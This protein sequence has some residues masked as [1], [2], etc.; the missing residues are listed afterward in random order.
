MILLLQE[1]SGEDLFSL[2][3][4]ESVNTTY[5]YALL[6]GIAD[7]IQSPGEKPIIVENMVYY[8]FQT[9][10]NKWLIY[11]YPIIGNEVFIPQ[12]IGELGIDSGKGLSF[13]KAFLEF[14]TLLKQ[15]G[16]DK[17]YLLAIRE[18][19]LPIEASDAFDKLI[20]QIGDTISAYPMKHLGYSF[21]NDYYSL[22]RRE[23]RIPDLSLN[24]KSLYLYQNNSTN[25]GF[26]VVSHSIYKLLCDDKYN[27]LFTKNV[28]A[29]WIDFTRKLIPQNAISDNSLRLLIVGNDNS[30]SRISTIK[31]FASLL[32]RSE[33]GRQEALSQLELLKEEYQ[34]L[35][36]SHSSTLHSYSIPI[37]EENIADTVQTFIDQNKADYH[38][39]TILENRYS[40]L[41]KQ[42]KELESLIDNPMKRQKDKQLLVEKYDELLQELNE[43]SISVD[44]IPLIKYL[45]RPVRRFLLYG[46]KG[47]YEL[48]YEIS[49]LYRL[50]HQHF[51]NSH[52]VPFWI[53]NSIAEYSCQKQAKLLTE[54]THDTIT[55]KGSESA[56]LIYNQNHNDIAIKIS[57]LKFPRKIEEN[58][59]GMTIFEDG[60]FQGDKVLPL[61]KLND[62]EVYTESYIYPL[63]GPATTYT[64]LFHY[65]DL[66]VSDPLHIRIEWENYLLFDASTG[67][68]RKEAI[69]SRA[70]WVVVKPEYYIVPEGAAVDYG[71]LDRKWDNYRVYYL[72]EGITGWSVVPIGESVQLVDNRPPLDVKVEGDFV[73]DVSADSLTVYNRTPSL[74]VTIPDRNSINFLIFTIT[75]NGADNGTKT[76]SVFLHAGEL[77]RYMI[78]C[79]D[80]EYRI[81]LSHEKLIGTTF[82]GRCLVRL[83]HTSL[84]IDK[85]HSFIILPQF[86]VQL[87]EKIFSPGFCS[88]IPLAQIQ[89]APF[90][91]IDQKDASI[92]VLDKF[93][94]KLLLKGIPKPEINCKIIIPIAGESPK[95]FNLKVNL[96]VILFGIVD[97]VNQNP[98]LSSSSILL[99]EEELDQ[100]GV[101]PRLHVLVPGGITCKGMLKLCGSSRV[102]WSKDVR[103]TLVFHLSSLLEELDSLPT[104]EVN[105]RLELQFDGNK[106]ISG[107]IIKI[108]RWKV[109]NAK[110]AIDDINDRKELHITWD[111]VGQA[112]SRMYRIWRGDKTPICQFHDPIPIGSREIR[113]TL[114]KDQLLPGLYYIQ[115]CRLKD[116]WDSG[117]PVFP[118]EMGYNITQ[119]SISLKKEELLE[120]GDK[121]LNNGDI[122]TAIDFFKEYGSENNLGMFWL[123]KIVNRYF[124]MKDFNGLQTV[125]PMIMNERKLLSDTDKKGFLIHFKNL[126]VKK[127]LN[128]KNIND[129][130]LH[131]VD[132]AVLAKLLW[133]YSSTFTQY[134]GKRSQIGNLLCDKYNDLKDAIITHENLS[135]IERDELFVIFEEMESYQ[136]EI[137]LRDRIFRDAQPERTI[138]KR[139]RRIT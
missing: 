102:I 58:S 113:K 8:P 22:V 131:Q 34:C 51:S 54:K 76:E 116:E 29:K 24:N 60:D 132:Y 105:I 61:Y 134:G 9:L 109:N 43:Y 16:M 70:H 6:R 12:K 78:E 85:R 107:D 84:R 56:V 95:E 28:I 62:N 27:S 64:L 73:P 129:Y 26:F 86:S 123:Q 25:K 79:G 41:I 82:S 92:T 45:D 110:I 31:Q 88:S 90:Y 4:K 125:Y 111:E 52:Q 37:S 68:Y 83:R 93:S 136:H 30:I 91:E 38:K 128:E 89:H 10:V 63:I 133:N 98:A 100:L 42:E 121:C 66:P 47:T 57:K 112:N 23:L 69:K 101:M 104:S 117:V 118:G 99:T 33:E 65:N 40:K 137:D 11:Y 130:L 114:K 21:F 14:I 17:S 49:S 39:L 50:N 3:S 108:I 19:I 44:P 96:P 94:D 32:D 80:G 46:G 97:D 72:E 59:I 18:G 67:I 115:F 138:K 124:Y 55:E 7:I 48:L 106:T 126:L 75:L 119:F 81:D 103:N 120:Q 5:K 36:N 13:R 35:N 74:F 2:I 77:S 122:I 15:T 20:K 127:V 135:T 87:K 53:Q 71:F 139:R 1:L